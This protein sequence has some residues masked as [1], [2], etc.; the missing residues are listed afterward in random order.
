MTK[1]FRYAGPAMGK[2]EGVSADH[3]LQTLI[4]ANPEADLDELTKLVLEQARANDEMM[5]VI[6]KG[7]TMAAS[8]RCRRDTRVGRPPR[9][10]SQEE[11]ACVAKAKATVERAIRKAEAA[12]IAA[13]HI[14]PSG[15]AVRASTGDEVRD[16]AGQFGPA[17][18]RIADLVLPNELVGEALTDEQIQAAWDGR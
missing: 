2:L 3:L 11:V 9:Q 15:L 17:L 1:H 10:R 12:F 16:A 7:W 18:L 8:L 14:L 4:D 6:V 13:A 5:R